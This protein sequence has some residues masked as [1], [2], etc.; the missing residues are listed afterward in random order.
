MA[1]YSNQ[2]NGSRKASPNDARTLVIQQP[3]KRAHAAKRGGTDATAA[4]SDKSMSRFRT[5]YSRLDQLSLFSF[6]KTQ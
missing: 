5:Q 4:V 6:N 3:R 1:L 2:E